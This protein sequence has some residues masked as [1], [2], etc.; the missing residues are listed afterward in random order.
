ME[1]A[2]RVA[3]L[4][5]ARVSQ[6]SMAVPEPMVKLPGLVVV[7]VVPVQE[8]LRME[9]PGHF[10]LRAEHPQVVQ[11]VVRE[12]QALETAALLQHPV[13]VVVVRNQVPMSSATVVLVAL[14]K[15]PLLTRPAK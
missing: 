6:N 10:P 5:Q 8:M 1:M 15:L 4:R 12:I 13:V 7:V 11:Q 2:G 14:A 3:R 9:I